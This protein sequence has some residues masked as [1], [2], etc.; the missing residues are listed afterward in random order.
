MPDANRY[1]PQFNVTFWDLRTSFLVKVDQHFQQLDSTSRF[2]QFTHFYWTRNG[3]WKHHLRKM[4][5]L[6]ADNSD[7]WKKFSIEVQALIPI[8]KT[9]IRLVIVSCNCRKCLRNEF[10]FTFSTFQLQK[11]ILTNLCFFNGFYSFEQLE[12]E[13]KLSKTPV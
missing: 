3:I 10:E 6:L 8:K 12:F 7:L 5:H 4:W 9:R 13:S 1:N 2:Y 11:Q